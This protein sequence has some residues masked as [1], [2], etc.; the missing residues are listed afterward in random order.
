VRA[1]ELGLV[2]EVRPCQKALPKVRRAGFEGFNCV[3]DFRRSGLRE[4]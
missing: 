1:V 2:L 4:K 3:L